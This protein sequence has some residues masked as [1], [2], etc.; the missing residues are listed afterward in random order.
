VFLENESPYIPYDGYM[1]TK[2]NVL[3]DELTSRM[4]RAIQDAVS[5]QSHTVAFKGDARLD[6]EA[7]AFLGIPGSPFESAVYEPGVSISGSPVCYVLTDETIS[8]LSR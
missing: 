5:H 3:F 2:T 7:Q 6:A 8:S 1:T 4:K